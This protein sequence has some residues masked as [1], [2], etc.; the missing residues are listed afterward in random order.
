M[1]LGV[2]KDGLGVAEEEVDGAF[3]VGV[4]VILAAVVSEEGVLVAEDA[5]VLEDGAIGQV[6]RAANPVSK[7]NLSGKIIDEKT[8]LV[9]L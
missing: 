6:V 7:R 9:S 5:A 8:I 1:E 3:D 4:E 2:V